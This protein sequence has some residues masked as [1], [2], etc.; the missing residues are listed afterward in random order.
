MRVRF[1][2]RRRLTRR[3]DDR[4]LPWNAVFMERLDE[5][6]HRAGRFGWTAL[7]QRA[8]SIRHS[9]SRPSFLGI[10]QPGCV[11]QPEI[12]I[13]D[14]IDTPNG[15]PRSVARLLPLG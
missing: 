15:V 5:I 13:S 1:V 4:H 11:C 8:M 2:E 14:R 12:A 6:R 10:P 7:K 9:G 3:S